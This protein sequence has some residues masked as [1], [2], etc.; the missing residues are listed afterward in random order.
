MSIAW[1]FF[2]HHRPDLLAQILKTKP[3]LRGEYERHRGSVKQAKRTK[4]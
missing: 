3:D 1:D 2:I 4:K